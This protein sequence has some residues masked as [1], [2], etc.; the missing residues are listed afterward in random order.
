MIVPFPKHPG[1]RGDSGV[2]NRAPAEVFKL[3]FPIALPGGAIDR[4][5]ID[6]ARNWRVSRSDDEGI[7]TA[8]TGL[9]T[10][11]RD[12]MSD[13]DKLRLLL[14]IEALN[15]PLLAAAEAS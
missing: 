6:F 13:H 11:V 3:R 10:S 2:E 15:A 8:I 12:Q 9:P 7:I 4:V 5:F 1:G 14:R